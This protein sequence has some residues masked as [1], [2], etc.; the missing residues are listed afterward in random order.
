MSTRP[1]FHRILKTLTLA[2]SAI[3]FIRLTAAMTQL[4]LYSLML[5]ERICMFTSL[6]S[7]I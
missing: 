5:G 4:L 7:V 3:R 2:L 6:V 1:R